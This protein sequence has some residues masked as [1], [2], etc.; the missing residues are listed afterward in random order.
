[1]TE[2]ARD[3]KHI[4]TYQ[5]TGSKPS[6]ERGIEHTESLKAGSRQLSAQSERKCQPI[7]IEYRQ[8]T[9]DIETSGTDNL[10]TI[11]FYKPLSTRMR[12][13]LFRQTRAVKF[14]YAVKVI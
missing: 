9:I 4:T 12:G 13:F 5:K 1:M 3:A 11:G 8:Y 7:Y 6:G 14:K 10:Q 2:T